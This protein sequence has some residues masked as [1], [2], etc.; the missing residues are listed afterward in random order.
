MSGGVGEG[1]TEELREKLSR[2]MFEG[3]SENWGGT[4]GMIIRLR[5]LSFLSPSFSLI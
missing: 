5:G 4:V 1:T 2:E 3:W